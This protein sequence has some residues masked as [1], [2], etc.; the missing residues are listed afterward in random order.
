M[1]RTDK[2]APPKDFETALQ[3]LETLVADME[4]GRLNLEAALA[5]YQRGSLLAA[6]CQKTLD[7]ADQQVKVLD[8]GVLKDLHP[9][10]GDD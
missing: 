4:S 9:G 7:A 3:E 5:A 2:N 8:N 10:G 6:Y 1:A